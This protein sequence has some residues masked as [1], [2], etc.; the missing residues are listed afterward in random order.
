MELMS[1]LLAVRKGEDVMSTMTGNMRRAILSGVV[2]AVVAFAATGV[3]RAGVA[4]DKPGAILIFPKIV[5]DTSGVFGPPTDTE[6]QITNTSNS[7]I[8]AKCFIVNATSFCSNAPD[9]ACTAES[10]SSPST[11]RCPT[12]GSCTARW[13]EN[14]FQMILTKRQPITWKAS[15]GRSVFPCDGISGFCPGGQSNRAPDG[16]PSFIPPAQTDPFFGE[17]KCIQVSASDL[18][19]SAGAN[20]ANNFAGDLKGEATIVAA[21][22]DG[23][24]DARKYN[25]VTLGANAA[26]GTNHDTTLLLGPGSSGEYSACPSVL[27]MEHLFDGATVV[28]HDGNLSGTVNTDLTVIPCSEDFN[29]QENNLGGATLQFLVFNEF[30]QRL[31]AST[32]FTCWREVQ[33]SDIDTRPGAFGNAQSIFNVGVQGTLAGQTRI[34]PVATSSANGILGISEERWDCGSG[35]D[36]ICTTASNLHFTGVNPDKGDTIVL[37]AP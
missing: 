35:P 15:D 11:R 28:T 19:P 10:E 17:I 12:G 20:P 29:L 22:T 16:A 13:V 2:G 26:A 6:L 23:D 7:V 32:N 25:G 30:E 24:V 14:D 21:E 9:V 4:S 8:G 34:R 18:Q 31:S 27:I 3:A 33:L 36:G 37:P 5:V 1:H